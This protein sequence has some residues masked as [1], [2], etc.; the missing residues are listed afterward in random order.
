MLQITDLPPQIVPAVNAFAQRLS[1]HIRTH[2]DASLEMHEEGVL[3]AWRAEGAAVLAGVVTAA[4]TGADPAARPPRSA[5]PRCGRGRAAERWRRRTVETQVGGLT[6]TRTR[7]RCG[8][9]HQRW[10][11]AD[12]TLGL[13]PRQR[14]S[15]GLARWEANVAA[16]TTFREAAELLEE[17]AG[18][19]VGSETVRTH[20][21]RLGT[22]REGQQ[23]RTMAQVQ[24]T[25]EPPS[26]LPLTP[27]PGMLV[28][29]ADG[30]MVR[31]H[32]CGPDG[33]PWHEVKLGIVG[34]WTGAR[35]EAHLQAPSYV[36]AREK[37]APF[38]R[39]LG[40]EAARRGALDV[41]GWRG[42]AADGGGHEAILRPVV[43]LGDGAK[44]IWDEVATT[45]GDERT[46]IVDWWHSAEHL[47]D[48]NKVLHG[49]GTSEATAWVE[50]AKHLLWRHGP[51]PLL[52]L[53][54]Q[55]PAPNA[56]ALKMLQREHGYFTANALRMQYPLF[57]KRGLPVASGAVEGGAKHLVQ[58][59]MKRAGMR[60]SEL[61]A[62]AILH[63]RCD[64]LSA[65]PA[66]HFAA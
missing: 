58:Q 11:G 21:E 38:A 34:G 27:T 5:C 47:W 24:A 30:V 60:W 62:R 6:F 52:A 40:T 14:T 22:E 16:R 4:T 33:S 50:Q 8:V 43:V 46:E 49:D 20:A 13:R 26:A 28:V 66:D 15:A 51:Q 55:T 29:E 7:Y 42:H 10:S 65:A 64:S 61:G 45:F 1:R 3:Q 44:W 59:R 35:P 9:C 56:D 39:R 36:A 18:V 53:L 25:H 19:Q 2:R 63:L 17:L 37:A 41:V 57:R 32:D 12:R 31:Y 54:Q 48:L 23:R